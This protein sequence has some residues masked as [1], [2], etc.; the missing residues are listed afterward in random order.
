[1]ER[2]GEKWKGEGEIKKER[3]VGEGKTQRD[4]RKERTWEINVKPG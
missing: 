1:M 3:G 2:H 4:E